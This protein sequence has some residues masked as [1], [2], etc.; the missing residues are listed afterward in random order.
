MENSRF[1]KKNLFFNVK[2][3]VISITT[4]CTTSSSQRHHC[5]CRHH[6][7]HHHMSVTTKTE[8]T[9]SILEI[10]ENKKANEEKIAQIKWEIFSAKRQDIQFAIDALTI[11]RASIIKKGCG[12]YVLEASDNSQ[13]DFDFI[14]EHMVGKK[15]LKDILN[16]V[17]PLV[18]TKWAQEG[19][20]EMSTNLCGPLDINTP[21]TIKYNILESFEM[22][23][24]SWPKILQLI[25][26][27]LQDPIVLICITRQSKNHWIMKELG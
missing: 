17:K 3:F 5:R 18:E 4:F 13:C 11:H 2:Q 20:V 1:F 12:F 22:M 7:Y 9:K 25:E 6:H 24:I 23:K 15:N 8:I 21:S 10:D 16:S 19:Q 26:K 27:S 14:N